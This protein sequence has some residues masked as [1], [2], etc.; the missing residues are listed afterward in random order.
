[1][2]EAPTFKATRMWLAVGIATLTMGSRVAY[3][4]PDG[5]SPGGENI[6]DAPIPTLVGGDDHSLSRVVAD[7]PMFLANTKDQSRAPLIGFVRAGTPIRPATAAE[8]A[9][10]SANERCALARRIVQEMVRVRDFERRW[11]GARPDRWSLMLSLK[12]NRH[13]VG[14][15]VPLLRSKAGCAEVKMDKRLW[16]CPQPGQEHYV[17]GCLDPGSGLIPTPTLHVVVVKVADEGLAV[18]ASWL[19]MDDSPK[20]D[21]SSM[22]PPAPPGR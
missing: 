5:G 13:T 7:S 1:M 10:P 14:P 2:T 17:G 6:P 18:E 19:E 9:I 11:L 15:E 3:A 4:A 20:Q 16:T 12:S 21:P 22:R 8:V